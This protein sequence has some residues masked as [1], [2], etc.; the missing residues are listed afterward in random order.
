MHEDFIKELGYLSLASRLK[1]I[2]DSMIHSGRQMYKNLNVDIEPNWY[3]IFKLLEKHGNLS[4]TDIAE[5][6]QFSHPSVITIINKMTLAGYLQSEPCP[7][8]GRRQWITL[9]Q[10]AKKMLPEYQKLWVAGTKGI[11]NMLKD[12]NFLTLL[13]HLEQEL[14]QQSFM[15]RTLNEFNNG[16]K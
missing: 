5:K 13:D 8:D 1:R 14:S 2:S 6:L 11:E 12:T 10:K 7:T 16:T 4:V 9:T 15:E 3:L